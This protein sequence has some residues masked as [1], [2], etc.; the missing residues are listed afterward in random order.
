M[1]T[2]PSN[3]RLSSA[4]QTCCSPTE[5]G[6]VGVCAIT[7][8]FCGPSAELDATLLPAY[9]ACEEGDTAA[10]GELDLLAGFVE[11]IWRGRFMAAPTKRARK[12]CGE[13]DIA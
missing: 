2:R 5:L 10:A 8:A 13:V 3:A 4:V 7:L 11:V 6:L 1:Q 12:R 9:A